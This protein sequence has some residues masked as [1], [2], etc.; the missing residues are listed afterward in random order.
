MT[1]DGKATGRFL[2]PNLTRADLTKADLSGVDLTEATLDRTVLAGANLTD[3]KLPERYA[4]LASRP[5]RAA[6]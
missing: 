4:R 5:P 2:A 3:T 6:G 1:G